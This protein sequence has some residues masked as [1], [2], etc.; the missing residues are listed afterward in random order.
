MVDR[1]RLLQWQTDR[2]DKDRR[3]RRIELVLAVV[4]GA[5]IGTIAA[6][7]PDLVRQRRCVYATRRTDARVPV[8][9]ACA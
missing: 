9:R 8:A 6:M 2:D 3:W 1:N 5:V 4:A 7:R